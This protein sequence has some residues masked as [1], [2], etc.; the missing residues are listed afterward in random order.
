MGD[1]NPSSA[2]NFPSECK[3]WGWDSMCRIPLDLLS[4]HPSKLVVF[5]RPSYKIASMTT[6]TDRSVRNNGGGGG[7]GGG[8]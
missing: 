4:V 6:A 2:V 8:G 1:F 5:L 3:R 7:G